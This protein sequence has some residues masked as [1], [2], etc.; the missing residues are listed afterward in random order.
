MYGWV[1]VDPYGSAKR[2]SCKKPISNNP[3]NDH[4]IVGSFTFKKA[5]YFIKNAEHMI[6]EGFKINNEYYLDNVL[7]ECIKNG[8]KVTTFKIDEYMHYPRKRW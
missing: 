5:E 2:V 8:L 4:A 3:I 7:I 1:D 6:S